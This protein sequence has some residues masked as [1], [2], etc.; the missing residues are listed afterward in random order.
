RGMMN[1]YN[2]LQLSMFGDSQLD[3]RVLHPTPIKFRRSDKIISSLP[4]CVARAKHIYKCG[5][6]VTL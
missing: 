6:N 4:H 3:M 5:C 2:Y 1:P